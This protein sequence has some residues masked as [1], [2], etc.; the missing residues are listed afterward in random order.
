MV[1]QSENCVLPIDRQWRNLEPDQDHRID[2]WAIGPGSVV[3]ARS[4]LRA[5]VLLLPISTVD[6]WSPYMDNLGKSH[7][8]AVGV[9]PSGEIWNSVD[10]QISVSSDDGAT[11]QDRTRGFTA[12]QVP[13]ILS[14]SAGRLFAIA[15]IE[16]SSA[17][18]VSPAGQFRQLN[19]PALYRS[20]D[21]GTS[22]SRILD[23]HGRSMEGRQRNAVCSMAFRLECYSRDNGKAGTRFCTQ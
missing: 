6:R 8:E 15:G 10:G 18:G 13:Q 7:S 23:Q 4:L 22:W 5:P 14:D 20:L 16:R 19:V 1:A 11:W 12:M 3:Y 21:N 2:K 9:S 17:G